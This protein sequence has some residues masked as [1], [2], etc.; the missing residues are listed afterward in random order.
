M[1]KYIV[2]SLILTFLSLGLYSQNKVIVGAERFGEYVPLLKNKKVSILA[3]QTSVVRDENDNLIHLLDTLLSLNV[4]VVKIFS[5]EHGFRGNVEAGGYVNN[6]VDSKTG[7]P[8]VSLYGKNKKPTQEQI[9]DCEV[10]LFDLQD[11]GCRF[12]TYISTL[13]YIM[14]ACAENNCKLIVLD[15]PNPNDYIDGPVLEAK[16]KSFV[17]MHRVPVLHAMTIG[18]YAKMI[19]GEGWLENSIQCDLQVIEI[20]GWEHDM[21]EV[22]QLFVAP[23][24]NLQTPKA[25]ELYPSLC[26]FEGTKVSVGR[27]T[28]T[29]FEIIGYP[30][31][32]DKTF[33]FTPRAIKGV[34]DNPMYK[35][36]KCYGMKD[37]KVQKKKLD[38][39]FLIKM[40][41]TANKKE[42][43]FNSFFDKLAGT[44]QLRKQIEKG[45]SQEEIKLSWQK[46]IEKFKKIRQ[47]YLLYQ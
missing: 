25:I 10:I 35:D 30:D 16:F 4:D 45:L 41:K 5:P 29:P 34:S 28:D 43:F 1:K 33:S 2:L 38:L 39:S 42:D 3:N 13:H 20:F 19:N 12:Y 31:Y 40:Y 11:V 15:R 21:K 17:G 14:E 36:K 37:L 44:D 9:K 24:P 47:K 7:I 6:S 46:D 8:I 27:G 26:F 22:Y 23:S 32:Y 18:E